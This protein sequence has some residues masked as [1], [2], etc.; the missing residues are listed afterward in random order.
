MLHNI[1]SVALIAYFVI[2]DLLPHL[3]DPDNDNHLKWIAI[4]AY[5]AAL[6]IDLLVGF[7]VQIDMDPV[8][9][10]FFDSLLKGK[11]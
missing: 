10:S 6:V 8:I 7:G 9:M 4:P 3:R 2:S 5:T 1:Y 11:G